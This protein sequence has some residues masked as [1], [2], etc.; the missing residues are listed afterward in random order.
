MNK[1]ALIFIACLALAA[2]AAAAKSSDYGQIFPKGQSFEVVSQGSSEQE[3]ANRAVTAATLY[4]KESGLGR[5][6]DVQD[7]KIAYQ[8]VFASAEQQR[9]ALGALESL[10]EGIKVSKGVP[11]I[12]PSISVK[13]DPSQAAQDLA[14]DTFR[15]TL[16]VVC[17]P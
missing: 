4:C 6:P 9:A 17:R 13:L 1:A 3:A 16:V 2:C 12:G 7:R 5:H 11:L 15:S 14:K 10:G 8:G